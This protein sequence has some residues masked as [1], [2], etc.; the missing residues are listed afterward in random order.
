MEKEKF[1]IEFPINSSKGVL[2]NCMS[3]PSGLSEWFCDDVNI[4]KDV[5][6]FI[7]DGSEEVARL[8]TKKKDEYVKFKW[9]ESEEDENDGTYFELRIRV[10]EMTGERAIIVT[11]FAEEDD[12]ED[13]RELWVAQLDRLRR[14]L[15][16]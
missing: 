9:L 13:A 7:W 14:V 4:K 3:T 16:G 8:V 2:Y 5:H 1:Q 12:I 11:D 10:D 15:G 6:T